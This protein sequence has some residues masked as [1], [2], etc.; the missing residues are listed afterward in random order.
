VSTGRWPFADDRLVERFRLRRLQRRDVEEAGAGLLEAHR[1]LGRAESIDR[2]PVLADPLGQRQE[3]RIRRHD[4]EPVDMAA[5][6]QVHR[7]DR[8]PHVGRALALDHVEL[9]HR[10][11]RMHA[12]QR[13]PAL[14]AG[15]GPIAVSAADIDRAQLAQHQQHLVEMV[16]DALSASISK[17]MFSSDSA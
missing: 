12:G 3:V 10:H 15:L 1:R 17:A 7:V 14:E 4:P 2:Q 13:A 16:G 5:I 11:D 8:H 6:E 9:L